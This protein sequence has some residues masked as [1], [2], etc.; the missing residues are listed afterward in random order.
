MRIIYPL[1]FMLLI[2]FSTVF[3]LMIL[4]LLCASI[5]VRHGY[6]AVGKKLWLLMMGIKVVVREGVPPRDA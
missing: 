6:L 4:K 3:G 1:P 5:R 2:M